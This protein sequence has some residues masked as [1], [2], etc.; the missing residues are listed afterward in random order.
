MEALKGLETKL[1]DVFVKNAPFQL[2]AAAKKW[3]VQYLPYINLLLGFLSLLAAWTLYR[4]ATVADNLVNYANELNRAFG[5]DAVA[6]VERLTAIVWLSIIVIAIEG[7]LYVLAFSPTKA[8]K[9]SGWDLLFLALLVNV[10]YGVVV[11]FTDYGGPSNLL[12]TLISTVIGLYFLFQIR[13][14]YNHKT[15][16]HTN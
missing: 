3:I 16:A 12:S 1:S 10:V 13:D 15:G 9:K 4:W 8:R 2:P 14:A 7:V 11:T 6:P 5:G